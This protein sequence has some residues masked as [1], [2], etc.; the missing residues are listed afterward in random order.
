M[1][2]VTTRQALWEPTSTLPGG[3]Y[4]SPEI[5]AEERE[6]IF[7][8]EWF[9]I[10]REESVPNPSD[11]LVV[12]VAGESIIIARTKQN[13][14]RAYY[15]TC[16][17]R[18]TKLCDDGAGHAKSNVFKCPY[19]AWTYTTDG[20]LVG[21]PNV[22]AEEG[23]DKSLYPLWSVAVDSWDGF[24]FVNLAEDPQPLADMIANDPDKPNQFARYGM[25]ELRIGA[26]TTYEIA[27][28]WKILTENYNECLHCPQVHPEL[29]ELVPVYRKG[30]VEEDPTSWGVHLAAEATSLTKTGTSDHPRL[31]GISDDDAHHYYGAHLFPNMN[32]NLTSDVVV[33][34]YHLPKGP[35]LTMV[36][37]DFLFRPETIADPSFDPSDLLEFDAIV[38]G[39][40]KAICEREQIGIKSRAYRRGGVY[41]YADRYVSAF[42]DYYRARMSAT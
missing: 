4:W 12:D 14:L 21:T 34:V 20:A 39:Q 32:L 40:D 7:F 5:Y 10:G 28:N 16:R 2:Q 9:C 37:E 30:R 35:E 38:A 11:Y 29:I 42:N 22:F 19:H 17:H 3:A 1:E 25:G 8:A 23:F 33:A 13:E 36:V 15:N 26:T 27:A 41:P 31:P 24:I 18:G 6:R